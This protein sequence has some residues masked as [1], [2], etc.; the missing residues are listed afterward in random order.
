MTFQN[1]FFPATMR[2][3]QLIDEGVLGQVLGFRA[4]YLHGGSANPD[5]PLK[6][7]LTA[8]AGGGV[9]ADLASHVLDLVDWLIGPFA[10]GDGRHADRLPR[11]AL[12]RRS[13]AEGRR[14]T[15]RTA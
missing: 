13:G 14:S 15:P 3:K 4:C 5:A 11:A 6:W 1:R 8:A 2:A 9:I 7:K 12:A 10:V